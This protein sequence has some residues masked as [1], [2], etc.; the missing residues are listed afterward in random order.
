MIK[1]WGI[2]K[3]R[4]F[5]LL[6]SAC[7]LLSGCGKAAQIEDYGG[8]A[9]D[10]E[11]TASEAAIQGQSSDL[12][13]L[14]E[15]LGGKELSYKDAVE[16]QGQII[17]MDLKYTVPDIESLS[18]YRVTPITTENLKEEDIVK[19]IFGD[20]AISLKSDD[21]KDLRRENGD[22]SVL[23]SVGQEILIDN[24]FSGY[25]TGERCASWV[26]TDNFFFHVYEGIYREKE[27]QLAISYSSL[28][29]DLSII[30]YPKKITD[31]SGSPELDQ[32]GVTAIDGMLYEFDIET[33][34]SYD[35]NT[36]MSDRPNVCTDSFED[37]SDK[38]YNCLKEDFYITLP[39]GER[40][41][42]FHDKGFTE[43]YSDNP[44]MLNNSSHNELIYYNNNILNDDD[45][46]GAVRN[47]YAASVFSS[48]EDGIYFM[49]GNS[50]LPLEYIG[51]VNGLILVDDKGLVGL[52]ISVPYNFEEVLSDN[53]EMLR[54]DTAMAA[55]KKAASENM[56]L[57][58]LPITTVSTRIA[59]K[60][61][62]LVYYPISSPDK[63]GECTYVPA[64]AF[65]ASNGNKGN[66]ATY[67]AL[68][69][70]NAVDGSYI[71]SY[72]DTESMALAIRDY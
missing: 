45:M 71:T 1:N 12:G 54:F 72:Y 68:I 66:G 41:L 23:I 22:S 18:T 51:Y 20:T 10:S 59:F 27:Y 7:M 17:D 39:K 15:K 58:Q 35:I 57:S 48:E 37:L 24:N 19:N 21:P 56:D 65:Y 31:M 69:L 52:H 70:I 14:T 67:L 11:G 61:I 30:L 25:F 9:M 46:S 62:K 40:G 5:A 33:V 36:I 32:Y 44:E 2:R 3:K 13:T 28:S 6:F 49:N 29:G 8:Q 47:G 60:D 43:L 4:Y 38:I 26:D 53:V 64:W 50:F 63:P 34:N 16:I 42:S 55:F